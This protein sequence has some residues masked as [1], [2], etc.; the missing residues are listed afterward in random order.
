MENKDRKPLGIYVHTPYCLQ[1]CKYC[2][3]TSFAEEADLSY[4]EQIIAEIRQFAGQYAD[5]YFVDTVYFGGGTPTIV[6][7]SVQAA[8]LHAVQSAWS[9]TEDA[10]I[11]IEANPETLT[12]EKL[13]GLR[14][15]GFNRISIGVQ[16]FNDEVLKAIGRVHNAEK[17][18]EAITL[19]RKYFD[20]INIDLMFGLPA[21]NMGVW[22]ETLKEAMFFNPQ[23]ISFYSL[24]L[25][26]GT[27]LHDD[28]KNGKVELPTWE[29]NRSMYHF[30]RGILKKSGYHHYEISNM[31]KPGYECRHNIKYWTM[32][33]YLGFGLSAHSFI[34]GYRLERTENELIGNPS[35]VGEL[36]GDFVFT[37]L[38]L[39]DGFFLREYREIFGN[40]FAMDFKKPL[41]ELI[42][43]GMLEQTSDGRLKFTDKGLDNTNNV[44]KKLLNAED[45][46]G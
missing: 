27:S 7:A 9:V 33:D 13:K 12:D 16:S 21:Q 31:A 42:K 8:V 15:A 2:D 14:E 6:D 28:Y 43:D 23:H 35:S 37:E 19:A 4:F 44:M 17:A 25:E 22:E 30:A 11:S 39:V 40:S 1:K 29:S 32:N 10:E 24:Q 26:E 18:R 5:K 41:D 36:K 20:N 34:Q 3:F 38:R 45:K 46:N